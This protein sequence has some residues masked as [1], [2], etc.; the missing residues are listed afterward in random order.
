MHT[1]TYRAKMIHSK[2]RGFMELTIGVLT[3]PFLTRTIPV[4]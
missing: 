2:L 4:N 3:P 1:Y